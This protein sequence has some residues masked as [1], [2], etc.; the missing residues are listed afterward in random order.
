[1]RSVRVEL[2]MRTTVER[3]FHAWMDER[4]LMQWWR[5]M[6]LQTTSADVDLRV[7]G[8]YRIEMSPA[9]GSEKLTLSGTF[10]VVDPP[11]SLVYSW[12]WRGG[13]FDGEESLV[14]VSFASLGAE[15][16]VTVHHQQLLSATSEK[17]HQRGWSSVFESLA[18][19]LSAGTSK[20]RLRRSE[21]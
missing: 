11:R 18:E 7:G 8:S 1:M 12:R 9:D 16:V 21:I 17:E 19:H 15:S 4:E 13:P 14:E 20:H 10:L 3:V 6:G 5:P 2:R